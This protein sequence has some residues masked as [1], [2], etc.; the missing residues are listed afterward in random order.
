MR[1]T[2]NVLA[3]HATIRTSY[4]DKVTRIGVSIEPELL[5]E[6]DDLIGKKGYSARSEALR[7]LIRNAL[8]EETWRIDTSDVVGTVNLLYEHEKGN[9]RERLM[10]IQHLHH[11]QISSSMHVH[12]NAEQCLEVLVVSGKAGDVKRLSNELCSV[13]GILQGKLT[14]TAGS[15][16]S[17]LHE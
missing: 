2:E 4:M 1:K 8:A 12:L 6:F 11:S 17:H 5:K 10:E 7:D 13:R 14:M 16:G 9:V 3:E 15:I